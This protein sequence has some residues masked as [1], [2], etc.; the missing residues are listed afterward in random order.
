MPKVITMHIQHYVVNKRILVLPTCHQ[1]CLVSEAKPFTLCLKLHD[2]NFV[3]WHDEL[4]GEN[5][6]KKID[7]FACQSQMARMCNMIV[8]EKDKS[9]SFLDNISR[10]GRESLIEAII[11][12]FELRTYVRIT[13]L[14]MRQCLV[15]KWHLFL[16]FLH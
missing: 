11:K 10:R 14:L 16:K 6:G 15:L 7:L 4:S 2:A 3:K 12:G 1:K 13:Q 9:P 5:W 8:I